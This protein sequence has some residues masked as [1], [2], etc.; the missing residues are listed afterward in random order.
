MLKVVLIDDDDILGAHHGLATSDYRVDLT[1]RTFER[2][3]NEREPDADLYVIDLLEQDANGKDR[4]AMGAG[5]YRPLLRERRPHA[6]IV[7]FTSLN[8]LSTGDRGDIH[9]NAMAEVE[10]ER[11]GAVHYKE[12]REAPKEPLVRGEDE[13]PHEQQAFRVLLDK[14]RTA[15]ELARRWGPDEVVLWF[16]SDNGCPDALR[17]YF[18]ARKYSVTLGDQPKW[19]A[20]NRFGGVVEVVNAAALAPLNVHPQGLGIQV[21]S[22]TAGWLECSVTI[23]DGAYP[24][25]KSASGRIFDANAANNGKA[26]LSQM[27]RLSPKYPSARVDISRSTSPAGWR[28]IRFSSCP[29]LRYVWPEAHVI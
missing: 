14:E 23:A 28:G 17:W 15:L 10:D 20:F 13:I 21:R 9:R 19:F 8:A 25:G 1:W 16:I 27:L 18:A 3:R 4:P 7:A 5:Q 26:A 24:E 2:L 6:R 22:Q 11:L 12:T 29:P